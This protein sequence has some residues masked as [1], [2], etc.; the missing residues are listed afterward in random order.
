MRLWRHY[1]SDKSR[2]CDLDVVQSK[3]KPLFD[4]QNKVISTCPELQNDP[5]TTRHARGPARANRD[6]PVKY[7]R[8]PLHPFPLVVR[9]RTLARLCVIRVTPDCEPAVHTIEPGVKFMLRDI[10]DDSVLIS[11]K[12]E[13][14]RAQLDD[15]VILSGSTYPKPR[16]AGR[17]EGNSECYRTSR[18]RH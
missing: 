5:S 9:R 3:I 16:H 13:W 12:N 14:Y 17:N 7:F 8:T 2:R 1:G 18:I 4:R 6:E 15:L 10:E 11:I